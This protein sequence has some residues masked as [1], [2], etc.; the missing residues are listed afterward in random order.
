MTV[1]VRISRNVNQ[2]VYRIGVSPRPNTHA[3]IAADME[4]VSRCSVVILYRDRAV[5]PKG[6]RGKP[7]PKEDAVVITTS[8]GV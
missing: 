1:D 4:T 5:V 8:E 2:Q 6:T 7:C 3:V